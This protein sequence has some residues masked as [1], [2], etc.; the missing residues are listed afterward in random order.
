[1]GA[2]SLEKPF[3][4]DG[5]NF[6]CQRCSACCRFDPGYVFLSQNDLSRISDFFHVTESDFRE[7]WCRKVDMGGIS[8]LS[9][10]EKT[11]YDCLY[12]KD[13]KCEVYP[14]RPLQCRSYPF[15][16]SILASRETWEEEGKSCPGINKGKLH[17]FEEI[18]SWLD[19]RRRE[20]QLEE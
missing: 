10:L 8:R 18:E 6:E 3:Y 16:H 11:D 7:K 4:I 14:A 12:W 19:W 1:M 13:G 9:L 15:W 17:S 2:K 20:P 5:L